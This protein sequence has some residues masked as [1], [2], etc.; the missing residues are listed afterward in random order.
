MP[1][2]FK[3]YNIIRQYIIYVFSTLHLS[4]WAKTKTW[5][6]NINLVEVTL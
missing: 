4:F 2:K 1:L 6:I 3:F 5:I